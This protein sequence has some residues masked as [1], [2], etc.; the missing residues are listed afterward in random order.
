MESK[1]PK[2]VANGALDSAGAKPECPA[3]LNLAYSKYTSFAP[4]LYS[5]KSGDFS[6]SPRARFRLAAFDDVE[7]A[8]VGGCSTCQILQ[9][10]ISWPWRTR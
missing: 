2:P 7:G 5:I 6:P 10:A 9:R 3:C 1:A 4:H 8:A